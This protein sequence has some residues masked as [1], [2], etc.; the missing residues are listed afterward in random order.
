MD[1]HSCHQCEPSWQRLFEKTKAHIKTRLAWREAPT[2]AADDNE[3]IML[4]LLWQ[5]ITMTMTA[6][7]DNDDDDDD[8]IMS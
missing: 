5:A 3:D 6:A 2:T 8:A 1:L 7:A 4:N